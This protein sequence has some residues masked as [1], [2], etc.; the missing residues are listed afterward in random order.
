MQLPLRRTRMIQRSRPRLI[1]TS[2]LPDHQQGALF[3]NGGVDAAEHAHPFGTVCITGPLAVLSR[4]RLPRRKRRYTNISGDVGGE[5]TTETSGAVH[6]SAPCTAATPS[7][8]RK[9]KTPARSSNLDNHR[10]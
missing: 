7:R 3:T 6:S 8:L 1:N 5:M 9:R 4:F 2:H 10:V